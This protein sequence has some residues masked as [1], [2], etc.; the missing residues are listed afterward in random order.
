MT[1][2]SWRADSGP[3]TSL[4]RR[5]CW[6][7]RCCIAPDRDPSSTAR[8]QRPSEYRRADRR[9]ARAV[10]GVGEKRRPQPSA[11]WWL[12]SGILMIVLAFWVSGEFFL[13]RLHAPGVSRR[14]VSAEGDCRHRPYL[15][16]SNPRLTA[17]QPA[18]HRRVGATGSGRGPTERKSVGSMSWRW[19]SIRRSAARA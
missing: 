19:G 13:R 7:V 10:A 16:D 12:L 1:L 18:A 11:L 2:V 15:P 9:Q 4:V 5:H 17:P 14:L 3:A 8:G 6:C